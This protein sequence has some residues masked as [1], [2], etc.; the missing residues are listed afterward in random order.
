M[1]QT[2][3]AENR[4]TPDGIPDG[5]YVELMTQAVHPDY[6]DG[7]EPGQWFGLFIR[8]QQGPLVIDGIRHEPNGCFVETVLE[9]AK[10][11]IEYYQTTKFNCIENA[12]ML[13]HIEA[14]L[15]AARDRTRRRTERGVEG[16]S[17][18]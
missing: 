16:T 9:A 15:E 6:D 14:A 18:V 12:E 3:T 7:A 10:Q 2:F 5:G 4:S 13:G 11:R 1:V 8:W 17:E